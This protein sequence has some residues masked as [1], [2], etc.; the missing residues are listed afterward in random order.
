M[1][2]S[3]TTVRDIPI[4][5]AGGCWPQSQLHNGIRYVSITLKLMKLMSS[6]EVVPC[7]MG[8]VIS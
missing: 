8:V 5:I 1:A 7:V 4:L 2:D 3:S 6:V